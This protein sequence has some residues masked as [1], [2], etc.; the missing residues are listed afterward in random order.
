[1]SDLA[2]QHLAMY[3]SEIWKSNLDQYVYS[4]WALINKVRPNE[5]VLDV[6]CGFNEFKEHIP[7]LIG[8]DPFNKNADIMVGIEDYKSELEFLA[9]CK[10]TMKSLFENNDSIQFN[11]KSMYLKLHHDQKQSQSKTQNAFNP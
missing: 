5:K 10:Q 4:G 9:E 6:G 8:I 1:M 2:Y 3:F 11:G 7:D